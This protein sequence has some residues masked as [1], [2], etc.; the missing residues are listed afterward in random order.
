[1]YQNQ[2]DAD[3]GTKFVKFLKW[4]MGP[5]QGFAQGL[6]YAALPKNLVQKVEKTIEGIQV[7]KP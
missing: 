1:M 4:A 7:K 3:K 6:E 2:P 5:G